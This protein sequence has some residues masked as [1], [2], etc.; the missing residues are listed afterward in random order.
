MIILVASEKGGVGKTTLS[1]NLAVLEA[2]DGKDVLLV[3]S[4]KQASA[5]DW[6]AI[7]SESS[8]LPA[9]TCMAKRGKGLQ[10]DI[11]KIAPKY[12]TV[13]I[14][15]GGQDSIELRQAL[16]IA[17]IVVVPSRASQFDSWALETMDTL[18][19]MAR[20]FNP[21]LKSLVIS[22][23]ASTNPLVSE[24]AELRSAVDSYP[25]LAMCNSKICDRISFRKSI[26]EGLAITEV[27]DKD[28]KAIFELRE[29]YKEI[30]RG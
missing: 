16:L 20:G 12:D 28:E 9:I 30:Y 8:V 5:S 17:D 3:D 23:C 26:K 21:N 14:D 6:A 1:A 27:S 19:R 15:C 2:S 29:L 25:D 4:D 10:E 7:R 11:A 24:D 13:I 18:I 22:N